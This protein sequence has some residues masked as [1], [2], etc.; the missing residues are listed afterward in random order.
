MFGEPRVPVY[1]TPRRRAGL[2]QEADHTVRCGLSTCRV[3]FLPSGSA[4]TGLLGRG[5]ERAVSQPHVNV[6]RWT[7]PERKWPREVSR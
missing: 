2:E 4:R 7:L 6:R 5:R 3:Q 1:E